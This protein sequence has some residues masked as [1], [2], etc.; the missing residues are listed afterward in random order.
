MLGAVERPTTSLFAIR[1]MAPLAIGVL[2]AIGLAGCGGS[3]SGYCYDARNCE[4]ANELDEDACNTRFEEAEELAE[5]QNC[6][7][8]FD[9]W[10]DCIEENSRCNNDRYQ[11]DEGN[12]SSQEEQ[13]NDCAD[14][15]GDF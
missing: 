12:C 10:F 11:V 2:F 4:G 14:F 1:A 3:I 7:S 9:E 15:Q 5:L 8:E 6:S 13:L